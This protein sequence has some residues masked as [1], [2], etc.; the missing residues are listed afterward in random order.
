M[1]YLITFL[2]VFLSASVMLAQSQRDTFLN[3][4]DGQTVNLVGLGVQRLWGVNAP[5]RIRADL[6][7]RLKR[8][9][10]SNR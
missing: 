7:V 8:S 6:T 3:A 5:T 10:R 2:I 1:K 9:P 4:P